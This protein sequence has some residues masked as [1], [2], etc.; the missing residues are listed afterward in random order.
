MP[1]LNDILQSLTYFSS[2]LHKIAYEH[3]Y[4][5]MYRR[6]VL[7]GRR[8]NDRA[9]SLL[10]QYDIE[11]LRTRKGRGAIL[12]DTEKGCF[13]FRE[14]IGGAE[15]LLLLDKIL[16]R[17][18]EKGEVQAEMLIPTREGEL[19][20]KDGDGIS[21][22]LKTYCEGRE[23]NIYDRNECM[24]AVKLLAL[25]H[26]SLSFPPEE[27]GIQ[28]MVSQGREFEKRN[29]ELRKIRKYLQQKSQKVPFELRLLNAFDLFLEQG[30]TIAEEWGSYHFGGEDGEEITYCHGDYQY[31][32]IIHSGEGWF[33]TNFEK[34]VPD[35][36]MRDL[37]L[38]M[39][40]LLEKS[41]WSVPLGRELLE[42]YG[43][44]RPISVMDRID[45]Y[46][47]LAYPEKFW[48]IA[49]FYY[50]SGKAWIP[51]RNSEK[52]RKLLEQEEQKQ[53]FLEAV[54]RRVP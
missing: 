54:F 30:L 32:N 12:C 35:S 29:R 14:Y 21:Y 49:N 20:V 15:K 36:P 25:L 24:E 42:A 51:E 9:V 37:Y 48:K 16:K 2:F 43:Q 11:V 19:A 5:E 33:L 23:C 7:G 27:D 18:E 26:D 6:S 3:G 22:I 8:V 38:L 17:I 44:L 13:I 1:K 4:G 39:R 40:K 34:C 41:G 28:L 46:H 31:H 53:D 50:N 45:L 47:R 52:L 10:D